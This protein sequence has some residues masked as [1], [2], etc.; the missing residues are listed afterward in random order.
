MGGDVVAVE[1]SKCPLCGYESNTAYFNAVHANKRHVRVTCGWVGMQWA[2]HR[3]T[4]PDCRPVE[5]LSGPGPGHVK[6]TK[7][8]LQAEVD[9]LKCELM[10]FAGVDTL[11]VERLQRERDHYKQQARCLSEAIHHLIAA[12]NHRLEADKCQN[13]AHRL[14]VE[15]LTA[16]RDLQRRERA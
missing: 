14:H 15:A 1:R 5:W 13:E 11:D 2:S 10:A 7:E 12:S 3:R 16:D 9:R 6:M 8:Q 4:H